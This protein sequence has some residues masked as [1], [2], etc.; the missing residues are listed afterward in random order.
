MPA[1]VAAVLPEAAT[2]KPLELWFLDEARVGQ[3]GGLT[4]VWA[5]RGTRPR[6]PRD[7][8]FE[9]AY[10]FGAV[11]PARGA[12]AGLVLPDV[13][14]AAM[15]VFLAE[16][17][18]TV[19]PGTHAALVLDGAG[20]HVGEQLVVPAN[21]TLIQLPPYSP[22]LNPVEN[23]WQFLRANWL[24]ISVFDDY[25]AIVDACCTAWN[26]FAERHD[27]VSSITSR[28]WAEVNP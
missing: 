25:P 13:S 28:Q 14:T 2:G 16:I 21:L 22:E 10:L 6:A 3:K 27:I 5:K 20:W 12:A 9:S 11:C 7:S 8:R 23:V 1:P 17:A 26:R 15:N 4:R 19:A 24:A 18:R